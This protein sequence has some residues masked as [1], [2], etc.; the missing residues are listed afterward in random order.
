MTNLEYANQIIQEF[1]EKIDHPQRFE[2]KKKLYTG[3]DLGTAYIVLAVVDEEGN[4]IAGAMRFAQ[5][6]KDGLVVDYIGAVDI[7]REL[8]AKI[9]DD[10]GVELLTAGVAYPPGTSKGDQKAISYVAEAAGFEVVTTLDEPTAANN[11]LKATNGAVV[12]IGGGTTG[13]A[14]LKDG[15]VT[16][17][18]DE[19]TGGTHFSLVISGARKLPFEEVEKLKLDQTK[20]SELLPAIKPVIQKVASI[21]KSHIQ[22]RNVQKVYLV[23]GTSCFTNIDKIIETELGLAVIKPKNPL[24]VTPLGIALGAKKVYE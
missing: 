24:L 21:I 7:V 17:V 1:K 13:I 15:K 4:P 3:V 18:A 9:E 12:D 11:V 10:L 22:D 19:P 14:I 8:K 6:V 20:H 23:G 16:Y 2:Q 5:V